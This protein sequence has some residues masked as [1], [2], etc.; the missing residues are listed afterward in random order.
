MAKK[1]IAVAAILCLCVS[2]LAV[3][4][5]EQEI[6]VFLDGEKIVFDVPPQTINDRTMVP[7]RAIFE[8]LGAT[9]DWNEEEQSITST[10]E[11][12]TI[13]MAI[14][15]PVITVNGEEITLDVAPVKIDDRTLVPIRAVAE[16]FEAEVLWDE[17]AQR[18]DI[19]TQ[20][21]EPSV[22]PSASPEPSASPDPSGSPEPTGSPEPDT[23]SDPSASASPTGSPSASPSAT[24]DTS[25][26]VFYTECPDVPDLGGMAGVKYEKTSNTDGGGFRYY[27]KA[28]ALPKD[29]TE[30]YQE[31]MEKAGFTSSEK[32]EGKAK[33]DFSITF[34]KDKVRVIVECNTA[35]DSYTVSVYQ[36]F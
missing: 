36:A 21:P 10:R 6:S 15:N 22:S 26:I 11:E 30:S 31:L 7:M 12:I 29:V 8:A 3:T 9:V 33:G 35:E 28:S 13:Y 1:I 2:M 23:S 20:A 25:G 14:D 27:Y 5:Q 19:K 32:T 34:R 16:S 18:V 17:D 24:P 4:A